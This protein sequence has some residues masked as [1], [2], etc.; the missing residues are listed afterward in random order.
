MRSRF[1]TR[2]SRAMPLLLLGGWALVAAPAAL[3]AAPTDVAATSLRQPQSPLSVL[4]GSTVSF[5][6]RNTSAVAAR[7]LVV[8]VA[9]SKDRR[10]GGGDR[11]V[12]RATLASLRARGARTLD[13]TLVVPAGARPGGY[14][15]V[16]CAT[17]GAQA[18]AS[19][20]ND[21]V[22][23][24]RKVNVRAATRAVVPQISASVALAVTRVIGPAGGSLSVPGAAG[25]SVTLNVPA[26][27]LSLP[28]AVRLVPVAAVTPGPPGVAPITAAIV[29]PEG[30]LVPGATIVLTPP[31]GVPKKL[32]AG[33]VFGGEDEA[34]VSAPLLP[35]KGARMDASM[36]GGYGLGLHTP[37]VPLRSSA[38]RACLAATMATD[39]CAAESLRK[40]ADE[41]M[42]GVDFNDQAELDSA[43]AALFQLE[44]TSVIPAMRA[45]VASGATGA[46]L[47]PIINVALS[48]ENQAAVL[49]YESDVAILA[50]V[51]KALKAAGGNEIAKCAKRS[52]GPLRTQT[53]IYK[54]ARAVEL[55]GGG[56]VAAEL[57][58]KLEADCL[59]KPYLLTYE[60]T[61]EEHWMTP[62]EKP[63]GAISGMTRIADLPVP[64]PVPG[65]DASASGPMSFSGLTCD[66]GTAP[67]V[68]GCAVPSAT[69]VLD[70]KIVD[71]VVTSKDAQRCG[72]TVQV[73]SYEVVFQL[74]HPQEEEQVRVTFHIPPAAPYTTDLLS[75]GTFDRALTLATEAELQQVTLPDEG[76]KEL[77][78]GTTLDFHGSML[79]IDATG[80]A[81]LKLE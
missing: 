68:I 71:T 53:S 22:A 37:G 69:A 46:E 14:W 51:S 23:S 17:S 62:G 33:F 50:E 60:M 30:L 28:T 4:G 20:T 61:T 15:L 36:F 63:P 56:S 75:G 25:G 35:G 73:P 39:P 16:A 66:V 76:G 79:S 74:R 48:I 13:I 1:R 11:I 49:G 45:A 8:S 26:K 27:A 42:A 9:L 57:Q 12:G 19:R 5:A 65:E 78:I 44:R 54:I 43:I 52:Q 7:R 58:A 29:E 72:R 70:A 81:T 10:S 64:V 32:L 77:L 18:Q 6:V 34:L 21:C 3:S 47:D 59:S 67:F 55:M 41:I 40:R 80:T 38:A 2:T 31:P 24:A